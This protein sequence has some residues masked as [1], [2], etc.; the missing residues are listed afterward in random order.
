MNSSYKRPSGCEAYLSLGERLQQPS[1]VATAALIF[2]IIIHILTF[3]FTAVLNALVMIAV[4]V[5]SR[6]RAHK[7]NILLALL[8][9]TD[10]TVGV[11]IQPAVIAMLV[12]F[13][14][15][16]PSGYC[17]LQVLFP[18]MSCLIN[19]S[20]F[21]LALISGERYLAM[22]HPF[23]YT[24]MVTEARLLAAS[25]LAWFLPPLLN[26]PLFVDEAVFVR[27][28][29]TVVGLTMA[30]IVFCHVTVYLETRRHE[31]QLAT[32]QVTQEAR[33]QFQKDKKAFK[34]TSTILAVLVV[35][36]LPLVV[37]TIVTSRYRSKLS[38]ETAHIVL[39]F[40]TLI[41]LLNS[42]LNPII[43]SVR[44]RQFR[45]AFIELTCR[46]VNITAA[47]EIEMRVFGAPNAVVK[48]ETGQEHERQDHQ[49]VNQANENNSDL[50]NN[51]LPQHENCVAEQPNNNHYLPCTVS[52]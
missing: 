4:K 2:L 1:P 11:I 35:C 8:A 43:Y 15:D 46:T 40:A 51:V 5:K 34:L 18:V 9:S 33:E 31:K 41:V 48:I 39:S 29:N 12:M 7:S 3:P 17:V 28:I 25:A 52:S 14:L 50:Q 10:F 27:F 42:L 24:T 47:E 13:L 36:F 44:K 45:V 49:N 26:V 37:C 19:A 32:Q 38:L 20:L 30:F 23:T 22:R 16:E 21:H 6:L